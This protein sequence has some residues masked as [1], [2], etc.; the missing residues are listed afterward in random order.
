MLQGSI[1]AAWCFKC[2]EGS[3]V[4]I[5]MKKM[6]RQDSWLLALD[7]DG[8]LIDEREEI[9]QETS[10][11]LQ[12]IMKEGH[13]VCIATGRFFASARL[14]AIRYNLRAPLI[15]CNGSYIKDP[16]TLEEYFK[17]V[18]D[19]QEARKVAEFAEEIDT[20]LHIFM[21]DSWFVSKITPRVEKGGARYGVDANL[22]SEIRE[23]GGRG[24][25]KMV[26]VDAQEK[27]NLVEE[28]T[29]KNCSKLGLIRSDPH[30]ID[31]INR[32]A[33]KGNGVKKLAELLG[34]SQD[35]IIAVGNYFNDIEMFRVAR[36]GIAMGD[37]PLEVKE[38]A[39]YVT[40]STAEGGIVEVIK[41]F[42]LNEEEYYAD[43]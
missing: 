9:N 42:I 34:Y 25:V 20:L 33:S 31:I 17:L 32:K 6:K 13:Q 18:I 36:I 15:S 8:T 30:S 41:R 23:W 37:S 35:R 24:I 43:I 2:R 39:D 7:L 27:I 14:L 10:H 12:A 19:G 28:W 1:P 38:A 29:R 5:L 21:D 11:Y 16:F 40:T 4:R 26:V 3:V 22:I